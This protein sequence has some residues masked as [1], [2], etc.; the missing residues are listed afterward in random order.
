MSTR[1]AFPVGCTVINTV[2]GHTVKAVVDGYMEHMDG[3][4]DL[5]LREIRP[6]GK[7]ARGRFMAPAKSCK[8][9]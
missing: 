5:I 2:A 4:T 3:T 8:L 1:I 6:C 9:A 7:L